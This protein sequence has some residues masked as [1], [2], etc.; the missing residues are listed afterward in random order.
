MNFK[1]MN[2]TLKVIF[3]IENKGTEIVVW[4]EKVICESFGQG[5]RIDEVTGTLPSISVSS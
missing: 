1:T 2:K 3:S 4:D 5:L